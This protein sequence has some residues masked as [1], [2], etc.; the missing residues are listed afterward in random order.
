MKSS[1]VRSILILVSLAITAMAQ[2]ETVQRTPTSIR[3]DEP[4][5]SDVLIHKEVS[6]DE[7]ANNPALRGTT[8]A[9]VQPSRHLMAKVQDLAKA[10]A[11]WKSK[12]IYNYGYEYTN[13]GSNNQNIAYPWDVTVRN[14]VQ[15]TALDGNH[16]QIL[17]K[18]NKPQT[19]DEHFE[20]IRKA[21]HD[22]VPHIEVTYHPS[23]GFPVDMYIV[24]NENTADAT[25]DAHLSKFR[26][27]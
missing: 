4:S 10:E 17:W 22:G 7:A 16:N 6:L 14:Q 18:T 23:L 15:A 21:F 8:N 26:V 24:Y 20:R 2:S 5:H 27:E 11:L 13:L 25:Y 1:S 3:M 9:S 12:R 19:M